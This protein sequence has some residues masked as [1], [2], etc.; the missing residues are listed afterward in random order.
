VQKTR[1]EGADLKV[2]DF[3][4]VREGLT[5]DEEKVMFDEFIWRIDGGHDDFEEGVQF[6]D[7]LGEVACV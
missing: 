1:R 2:Q 6:G 4:E 3:L 7:G 5:R